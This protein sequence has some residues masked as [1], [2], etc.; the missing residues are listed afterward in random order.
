[1]SRQ[2][3]LCAAFTSTGVA[4]AHVRVHVCACAS[5]CACEYAS[6]CLMCASMWVL[7]DV[8]HTESLITLHRLMYVGYLVAHVH[9]YG[10][11][12]ARAQSHA[13]VCIHSYVHA[14]VHVRRRVRLS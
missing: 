14:R 7:V 5:V 4:F 12:H 9:A 3:M 2:V 10:Y 11:V 13:S 1:M 8:N 6:V